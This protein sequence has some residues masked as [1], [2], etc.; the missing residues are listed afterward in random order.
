MGTRHKFQGIRENFTARRSG[1]G[2]SR[3]VNRLA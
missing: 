3:D 2:S 1:P